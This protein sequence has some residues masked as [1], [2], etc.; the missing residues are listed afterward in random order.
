MEFTGERMVPE[1]AGAETF[2]EHVERYRFASDWVRNKDVLDIA[3]GEGYG[4]AAL[5]KAGA[6][7][8]IGVDIAQE[9]VEHARLRY[10]IDAR[11][12]SAE[13]IPVESSSVDLVV[14]FETIEH[15]VN[16]ELFLNECVRVLRPDGVLVMSTPNLEMYRE[17][18]PNNPFHCSEMSVEQFEILLGTRFESTV[19]FGQHLPEPWFMRIRGLGRLGRICRALL[20][21]Q[22]A[23]PLSDELRG[24]VV[25]VCL[26]PL[27]SLERYLT[28]E[29]VRSANRDELQKSRYV[30]AV[31]NGIRRS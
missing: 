6:R 30:I 17:V 3:C 28:V 26:R 19:M 7:S 24:Q 21:P 12:G 22:R 31:A 14:S 16:P 18:A 27:S 9:A 23:L 4:S 11:L 20:N 2:W 8:V 15:V 29:A 10:Q 1:A 5:A 13:N 25:D